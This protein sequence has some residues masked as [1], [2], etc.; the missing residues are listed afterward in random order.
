MWLAKR[1]A[2]GCALGVFWYL[3]LLIPEYSRR[4]LLGET[5]RSPVRM[6]ILMLVASSA[7]T[8]IPLYIPSRYRIV[9][10][11]VVAL[12]LPLLGAF[13]YSIFVLSTDLYVGLP[14]IMDSKNP[15]G[16][17]MGLVGLAFGIYFLF[18]YGVPVMTVL[19][20][21]QTLY[22]II[23]MGFLHGELMSYMNNPIDPAAR[24]A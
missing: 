17:I 24:L 6:F 19:F 9:G 23:P 1:I 20:Y 14:E 8:V 10:R 5:G 11:I 2:L 18:V 3:A 13:T 21:T 16:R 15:Q 4:E 12:F 22:V 7:V